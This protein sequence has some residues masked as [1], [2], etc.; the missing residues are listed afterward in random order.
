[1]RPALSVQYHGCQKLP[2]AQ[3]LRFGW[4]R[5]SSLFCRVVVLG[6][7]ILQSLDAVSSSQACFAVAFAVRAWTHNKQRPGTGCILVRRIHCSC[8][9][10]HVVRGSAHAVQTQTRMTES[11]HWSNCAGGNACSS[12]ARKKQEVLPRRKKC[13][14]IAFGNFRAVSVVVQNCQC[15]NTSIRYSYSRL[16]LSACKILL[17]LFQARPPPWGCGRGAP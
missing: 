5:K 9:L 14:K 1:M 15:R 11:R 16:V 12:R 3:V 8:I 7:K 10:Q 6:S 4:W 2:V 17:L 13:V